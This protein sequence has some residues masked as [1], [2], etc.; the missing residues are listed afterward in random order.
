MFVGDARYCV[1][2]NHV[3]TQLVVHDITMKVNALAR[4]DKPSAYCCNVLGLHPDAAV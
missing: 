3:N 1:P 2:Y 4:G